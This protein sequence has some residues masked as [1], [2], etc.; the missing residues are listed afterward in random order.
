[1][2]YTME[3]YIKEIESRVYPRELIDLNVD[4]L[5]LGQ[6]MRLTPEQVVEMLRSDQC[7]EL[8]GPKSSLRGELQMRVGL[9]LV[10]LGATHMLTSDMRKT[11]LAFLDE[12]RTPFPPSPPSETP[13]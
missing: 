12:G 6:I 4:G 3:E 8:I 1:M 5:T 9:R 13:A 7:L 2:P 10:A 11:L